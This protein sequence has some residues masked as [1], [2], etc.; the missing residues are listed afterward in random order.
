MKSERRGTVQEG[1]LESSV[2]VDIVY[3]PKKDIA[4]YKEFSKHTAQGST[5][6]TEQ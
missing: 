4:Q 1:F 3:H 6:F 5:F 2:L